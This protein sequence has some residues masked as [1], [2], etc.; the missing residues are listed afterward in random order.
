MFVTVFIIATMSFVL[1]VPF[2]MVLVLVATVAQR[3]QSQ[4]VAVTARPDAVR[5]RRVRAAA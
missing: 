1:L 5:D 3:N 4:V 2:L